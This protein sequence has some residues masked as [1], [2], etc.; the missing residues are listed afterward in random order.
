VLQKKSSSQSELVTVSDIITALQGLNK[1]R[2][3]GSDGI[4]TQAFIFRGH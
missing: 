2:A 4:N 1:G 3:A